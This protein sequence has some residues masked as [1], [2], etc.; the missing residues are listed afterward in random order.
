MSGAMSAAMIRVRPADFQFTGATLS[1]GKFYRWP[2]AAKMIASQ[3]NPK[4]LRIAIT[5]TIRPT[6]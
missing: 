5:T 3:R 4:K 2:F 6:I 1:I